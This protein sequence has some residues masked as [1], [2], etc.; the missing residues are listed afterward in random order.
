[1]TTIQ[2]AWD[3][4]PLIVTMSENGHITPTKESNWEVLTPDGVPFQVL[5][6][7]DTL[8]LAFHQ[9]RLEVGCKWAVYLT[10]DIW[11]EPINYFGTVKEGTDTDWDVTELNL[12]I[13]NLLNQVELND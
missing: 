4:N 9:T 1:M 7:N 10:G 8:F 5:T 6:D 3:T 13:K 2:T 11:D 12:A